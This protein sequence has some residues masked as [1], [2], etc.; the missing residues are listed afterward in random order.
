MD[1]E[2]VSVPVIVGSMLRTEEV[3]VAEVSPTP[4]DVM[5][6]LPVGEELLPPAP[7]AAGGGASL[8]VVG[9][10][11]SARALDPG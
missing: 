3:L 8:P 5:P 2:T 9:L 4:E 6:P 11:P 1:P 7:E 10:S